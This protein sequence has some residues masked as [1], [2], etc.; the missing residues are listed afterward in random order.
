MRPQTRVRG[1]LVAFFLLGLAA[2]FH[3]MGG[4]VQ[5]QI[6]IPVRNATAVV[7]TASGPEGGAFIVYTAVCIVAG[8]VSVVGS[9]LLGYRSVFGSPSTQQDVVQAVDKTIKR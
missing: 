3:G 8:L 2:F 5:G 1:V 6:T 9:V 4:V 7:L